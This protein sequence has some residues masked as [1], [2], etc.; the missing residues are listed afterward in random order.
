[1]FWTDSLSCAPNQVRE[2]AINIDGRSE[3][4]N[5]RQPPLNHLGVK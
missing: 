4:D 5:R 3:H 2:I 1:M